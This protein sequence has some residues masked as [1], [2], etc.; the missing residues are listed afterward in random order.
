[1]I[2][3][4]NKP[5]LCLMQDGA[6]SHT[7]HTLDFETLQAHRVDVLPWSSKSPDLNPIK[8]NWDVISRVVRRRGV[9]NLRQF[10]CTVICNGRMERNNT[11]HVKR[12]RY[13]TSMRSRF[14]T[15]I[16]ASGGHTRYKVRPINLCCDD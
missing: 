11:S 15:V 4:I 7:A 13:V 12:L 10:T 16:E 3:V 1:M 2:S 6:A 9:A 5:G 14:Q 8:H